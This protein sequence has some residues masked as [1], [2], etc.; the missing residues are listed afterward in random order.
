MIL[1]FNP[2][3]TYHSFYQKINTNIDQSSSIRKLSP[4][5]ALS[6][7]FVLWA[8]EAYLYCCMFRGPRPE[9]IDI[10]FAF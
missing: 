8:E 9:I 7:L 6:R 3:S 10:L 5:Y 2:D 4:V 1:L